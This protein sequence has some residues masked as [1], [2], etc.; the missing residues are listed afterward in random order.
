MKSLD[1]RIGEAL[2]AA[3]RELL[4]SMEEPA[5]IRQAFGLYRGRNAWISVLITLAQAAAFVAGAWAAVEF[6]NAGDVL[7]ALKWGVSAA[8]LLLISAQ[9][10]MYLLSQMQTDRLLQALRLMEARLSGAGR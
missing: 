4:K 8:V 3:D 9:L 5:F 7:M 6:L 2:S 10:K 1:D